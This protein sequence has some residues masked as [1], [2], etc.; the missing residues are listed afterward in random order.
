MEEKEIRC[1]NCQT[2]SRPGQLLLR[3]QFVKGEIKC[4]RCGAEES[5]QKV[6]W[7]DTIVGHC[8]DWNIPRTEPMAASRL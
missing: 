6:V 1:P 4:P 3:A 7:S 5:M 2:N 8:Y